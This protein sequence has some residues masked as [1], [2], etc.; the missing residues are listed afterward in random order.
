[1]IHYGGNLIAQWDIVY[2]RKRPISAI[3]HPKLT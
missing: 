3:D 1:M 2:D